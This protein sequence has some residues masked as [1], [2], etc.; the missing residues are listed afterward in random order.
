MGEAKRKTEAGLMP[1]KTTAPKMP[2][3]CIGVPSASQMW[4]DTAMS[5][6]ALSAYSARIYNLA[7]VSEKNSMITDARTNVVKKALEFGSDYLLW[8]DSDMTFPMDALQRLISHDK[9]VVCAIYN[10]RVHPYE[11]LGKVKGGQAAMADITD[12]GLVEM[13][14]VPGGFMLV[15]MRVYRA[16][17]E[18]EFEQQLFYR[19]MYDRP[20]KTRMVSED[21]YFSERARALGF[22][23]WAD[24]ELT[25]K[26][27]HIGEHPVICNVSWQE[28]RAKARGYIADQEKAADLINK[29]VAAA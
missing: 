4:T 15:N 11:T 9:D 21:Y 20:D 8:I 3:I 14:Y 12:S 25:P 26:I 17:I 2:K 22:S 27:S 16:M 1:V 10:K 29:A 24:L 28:E 13:D 6:V 19:E 18:P 23:L 7:I 5:L